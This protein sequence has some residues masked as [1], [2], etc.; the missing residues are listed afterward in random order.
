MGDVRPSIVSE[1]VS[2]ENLKIERREVKN[3]RSSTKV[4]MASRKQSKV[5]EG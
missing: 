4:G 5:L 1:M 3:K 2:S